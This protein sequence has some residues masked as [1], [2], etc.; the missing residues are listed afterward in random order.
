VSILYEKPLRDAP[1]SD[2]NIKR[3]KQPPGALTSGPLVG[4]SPGTDRKVS[5]SQLGL[6]TLD[7]MADDWVGTVIVTYLR[8]VT[9][10][11]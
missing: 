10:E 8:Y 7:V 5:R 6:P 9:F 2:P 4:S 3:S 1:A 11:P